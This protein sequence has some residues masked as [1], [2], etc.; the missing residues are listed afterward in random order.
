MPTKKILTPL[1]PDCYFHVFNRGNNGEN[2]FFT[3]EN[4]RYF[5]RRYQFFLSSYVDTYAYCLIGNH[6]HFLIKVKNK[7]DENY[8]LKV[9]H[10]FRRL[11]QAYALSI[12]K[13]EGRSGSL[14]RKQFR[15]IAVNN[16]DYLRRLVFYIH[17]NPQK[18]QIVQDFRKYPYSSYR[19]IKEEVD[20]LIVESES[21]ISWFNDL[22][23]FI[24][25]HDVMHNEKKLKMISLEDD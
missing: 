3:K 10:Q 8:H 20:D 17:F 21:V 14:F 16:M 12:N 4:Y 2:L 6:F 7:N 1:L 18:H 25:Y 24:N 15:R 13:Q 5:L 23:D 19:V 22:E 9:S 11:F